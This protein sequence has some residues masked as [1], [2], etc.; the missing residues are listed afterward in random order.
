MTFGKIKFF[1][2]QFTQGCPI[3]LFVDNR[4]NRAIND[5]IDRIRLAKTKRKKDRG[6]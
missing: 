2:H 4:I 6:V 5:H 1:A 3:P